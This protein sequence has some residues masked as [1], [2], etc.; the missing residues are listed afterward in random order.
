MISPEKDGSSYLWAQFLLKI[1]VAIILFTIGIFII[2][3]TR[4]NDL[5]NSNYITKSIIIIIIIIMC[6]FQ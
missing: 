1:G 6:L 4:N 2:L 3:L 5:V